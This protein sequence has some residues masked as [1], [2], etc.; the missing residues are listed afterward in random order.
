[1]KINI[2]SL[3][4]SI[5]AILAFTLLCNISNAQFADFKNYPVTVDPHES[6]DSTRGHFWGYM[7]GSYYTK[8]HG[9]SLNRGNTQYSVEPK[10]S[11]AFAI[12]RV[13]IG[14]D[15]FFNKQ[16]SVHVVLAHE[17]TVD[18]KF[19][20]ANA[21]QNYNPIFYLK[22]AN[23]EWE[24]VF[25]THLKLTV[26]AITTPSFAI[27]EEPFWGYRSIDRTVM[28]M[29]GITGSNDVGA[30]I[31]GKIWRK[32]DDAGMETSCV[33]FNFMVGNSTGDISD[34]YGIT[35]DYTIWKK[36]YGDL[37][38]KMLNDKL[39]LDIFGDG[40]TYAWTPIRGT[41]NELHQ[42]EL[43][44]RV[45][46]GYKAKNFNI[47]AE[48][49]EQIQKNMIAQ[50]SGPGVPVEGDTVDNTQTGFSVMAAAVLMRD[51]KTGA[52]ELSAFA[53]V[54]GYNPQVN[55]NNKVTYNTGTFL[56]D[57]Q[58]KDVINSVT[59]SYF[60]VGF[61]YQPIKQIHLMPNIWYSGNTDRKY[62]NVPATAIEKMDYDM[63][64]R[65]TFYYQFFKN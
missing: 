2:L 50:L 10:G 36:Y 32:K 48:Y 39:V 12:Q 27:T 47:S 56:V 19:T 61:D 9:D 63:V 59:E 64:L 24:N 26:G 62:N 60:V 23:M 55:Y 7:F 42:Y 41:N 57:G 21:D 40:H 43:T 22:Y 14:Y 33:G 31:G 13:Y 30:N 58:T 53:R 65:I 4:K 29:K 54:D 28:D 18:G 5:V 44:G 8:V 38:V 52:P 25:N 20:T 11:N 45:F 37:Y 49:F 6:A 3:P 16:F 51:K 15:Y 1:M 46:L 34:I 17:Q 35:A